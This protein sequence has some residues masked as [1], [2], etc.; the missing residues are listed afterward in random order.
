MA[1]TNQTYRVFIS[2]T[3]S[4]L[5][6]E[7]N[8]LQEQVFPRL[9]A[10][11]QQ[12]G[13][14]F[15]P[16]DLRWGVSEEASLDQQAMAICL[17]EIK[18]C[19]EISP[20]PNFLVLL[21]DRYGWCPP[22]SHIPESEFQE[23]L[24]LINNQDDL[25]LL[26][27]WYCLDENAVP[28]KW[29]LKPRLKGE[30]YEKY[31]NWQPV[32]FRL[33][34]ILA[35]AAGKLNFSPDR[36][37]PYTSSA[38]EQ[39]IAAGA[40]RVKEAPEHVFCFFRNLDGLPKQF[41]AP[42]FL[43]L[44][45]SRLE[46]NFSS[47]L[48]QTSQGFVNQIP[49]NGDLHSARGFA[50]QIKNILET[51]Q[52]ATPEEEVMSFVRQVLVDFTAKDFQNLDEIDWLVDEKAHIKQRDLKAR[53]QQYVPHNINSYSAN[54]TH[55]SVTG[56]MITTAHVDQLCDD[57]YNAL[58]GVILAEI[59]HPHSIAVEDEIIRIKPDPSLDA[60]GLAHR[61][62]AQDHLRIFVG[63]QDILAK[64]ADGLSGNGNRSLMIVGAG[65]TG[66]STLMARVIQEMQK[67]HPNAELV[68]RFIGVTPGSSDG[69]SLL[70]SLCHELS[71]RYGA[72]ASDI[73]T[74]YRDLV[75]ELGKRMALATTEKP[76]I[77]FLDSL[78][79]LS[80]SQ[81][82]R[83][84]IWLPVELPANVCVIVSTRPEDTHKAMQVKQALEM[85]LAGLSRQEGENLLSQW[86]ASDQ[87]TLQTAQ[88][89]EIMDKFD[90][91]GAP[92]DVELSPGNP[93]YLKLA[94]EE[95]RLW[96]SYTAPEQLAFGVKGIIE[97]NM[98]DRMKH[99][100][101]HGEALVSHA[102]GYMVASR[103]GLAEDELVDLLSRDL[104]VYSWF[105]NMSY[106][107]PS[108]L[109]QS[110]IKYRRL[111]TSAEKREGKATKEE[112]RT[113]LA[114]LK[115]IRNP[116]EL[117]AQFLQAVLPK[118]D[119]P[120]LPIVLWSR[121]S[122]DLAPYLTER[123]VDG[124]SLLNFYH[125]ELGDVSA[126]VFLGDRKDLVYHERLAD[127]FRSKADPQGDRTWM[128]NYIHGLSELPYHLTQAELYEE[129]FQ[130]LTNFKFLE[131]KAAE[132]GVL[133]R[134][135]EKGNPANTYTGV[136][137][138]QEDY[139]RALQVMP[140]GEGGM[141]DRAPLIL[142]ALDTSKGLMVY[143]PV[144]NKYSPV[145]QEMLDT[146]IRC[147]QETCKAPIKLNPFTVKREI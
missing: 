43:T 31:E 114:W 22:P 86:L 46:Y 139:E 102:L 79:Q 80:E 134:S 67:N 90:C 91:L 41:N 63:R 33:Q 88:F 70:D 130:T 109:I 52:K 106:H 56:D 13:A 65:G 49:K 82:A 48:S 129:V 26:R 9:R 68:Y 147:P 105:F 83:S 7:R 78:D 6:A 36:L 128:G 94:F 5:K 73:P 38:T 138:L 37:L 71:R 74:D 55:D 135:D 66:K 93:L 97:K 64:I 107:L 131:H 40:L 122:F 53:L 18:R 1:P 76:L 34:A 75:P 19:Q 112:E 77:L 116:P 10:L 99:E 145:T 141:S 3:F 124:S 89:M 110:A 98:I 59:E 45:K 108:D 136:L 8:A 84:L 127:Y 81:N 92:K 95:A 137:Q 121:L 15:Q 17:G 23:I 87:R 28:P 123:M 39:E 133:V 118:P 16:I 126:A 11:C 142:T 44:V 24:G 51:I 104:E 47:G 120:R 119:G 69:R 4:D 14:R 125:R 96:T 143:C 111:Q 57:V 58:S 54:W 144:C 146:V 103:Y 27:H 25:A 30:K 42:E 21:G 85:K 115:E 72:D 50:D 62:F 100:G 2:S 12:H 29:H 60:E 132:V 61:K 20:R 117:V 35:E 32:E 140:G 101:N 113:A